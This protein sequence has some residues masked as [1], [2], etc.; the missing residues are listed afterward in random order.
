[1]PLRDPRWRGIIVTMA[2]SILRTLCAAGIVLASL[3]WASGSMGGPAPLRVGTKDAPPFAIPDAERPSGTTAAAQ[4]TGLSIELWERIAD[5]LGDQPFIL[6][7]RPR[8]ADCGVC[9]NLLHGVA[10]LAESPIRSAIRQQPRLISYIERVV[11]QAGVSKGAL[12]YHFPSKEDLMAGT[13]AYL[14]ARPL[15]HAEQH[16]EASE[17]N[18]RRRL[19]QI[20]DR[21]M[22]TRAYVALLEILMA[23]RTHK[24][25]HARIAADL[26]ASIRGIDEHFLPCAANSTRRT[27]KT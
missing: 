21:L 17:F 13:A 23:A 4:W 10:T 3:F 14:L 8:T 5:E 24:V 19:L 20:W 12:Q 25:L 18:L 1:M 2:L 26:R 27:R 9:A 16:R 15:E 7:E 6:G 22:N 11:E